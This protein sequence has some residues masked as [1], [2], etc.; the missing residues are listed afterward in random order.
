MGVATLDHNSPVPRAWQAVGDLLAEWRPPDG[1]FD[2]Q[3]W[4]HTYTV[5]VIEPKPEG[6]VI[7]AASAGA[8]RLIRRSDGEQVRLTVTLVRRHG[9]ALQLAYHCNA[10][11]SCVAEGLCTPVAW[12]LRTRLTYPPGNPI[13]LTE[14][15]EEGVAQ[16]GWIERRGEVV[17]R[18]RAPAAWTADWC[19]F[20]LLQRRPFVPPA[21]FDLLEELSLHKPEQRLHDRGLR[22][23]DIGG[24]RLALRCVVQVGR[25]LLP[26]TWWLDD[27]GRV[28]LLCAGQRALLW[29]GAG[30]GV[31]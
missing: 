5:A 28:I 22:D 30:E 8:L 16:D 19:L 2:P 14:T 27:Q 12:T 7:A 11:L 18:V 21:A 15:G 17:R 13:P 9:G 6:R 24:R 23:V 10:E 29:R 4:D 20:E 25:G 26:Q 3:A 1:P 31:A